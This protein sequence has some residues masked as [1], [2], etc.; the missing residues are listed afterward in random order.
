MYVPDY[1]KV[2]AKMLYASS[3]TALQRAL[4]GAGAFSTQVYW[5]DLEDVS[6]RGW[7]A[8]LAHEKLSAPL[9]AEE[10]SLQ[11]VREKEVDQMLGTGARGRR[12]HVD[13]GGAG[14][15][16]AGG[17]SVQSKVDARA[18]QAL[19]I[20]AS[21]DAAGVVTLG[22]DL[23]SETIV[24]GETH[25]GAVSKTELLSH[26]IHT[27]NPQFTFYKPTSKSAATVFIYTCPAASKVKE[28]MVYAVNRKA[29]GRLAGEAGLSVTQELEGASGADVADEI[30][31]VTGEAGA[32]G[33]GAVP[34]AERLVSKP[35]FTRPKAP[36]RR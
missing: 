34:Q 6:A 10:K 11:D 30:G 23:A 15:S 33:A 24:L 9:T 8:H 28:R 20:L 22:I 16:A 25:T 13:F 3:S 27:E 18:K 1:A 2:R 14:A 36:G 4:G 21:A 12:S 17:S 7:Q 5:N 35:R 32:A 31:E 19:E 26:Y 29:V